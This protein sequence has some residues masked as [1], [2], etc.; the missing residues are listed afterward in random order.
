MTKLKP[1]IGW[2]LT[3]LGAS[4][5]AGCG[6]GAA[7]RGDW[8]DALRGS[9]SLD[10]RN[11]EH[12]GYGLHYDIVLSSRQATPREFTGAPARTPKSLGGGQHGE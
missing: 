5:I 2:V 11:I 12:L 6:T 9:L 7:V 10:C 1:A 4:A 3:L 8:E